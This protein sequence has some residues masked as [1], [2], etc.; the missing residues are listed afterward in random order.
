MARA[1]SPELNTPGSWAKVERRRLLANSH[2]R[3]CT[4]GVKADMPGYTGETQ[5]SSWSEW[6]VVLGVMMF[7]HCTIF[8]VDT[9]FM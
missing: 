6:Q 4:Q 5:K 3:S 1:V 2:H 7:R 8:R 9:I